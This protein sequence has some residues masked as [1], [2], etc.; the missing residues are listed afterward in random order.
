MK[1]KYLLKR[2]GA[3]ALAAMM[4][5]AS[6]PVNASE[7]STEMVTEAAT[8][9]VTEPVTVQEEAPAETEVPVE[10]EAPTEIPPETEQQTT[11]ETESTVETEP[12]GG[13]ETWEGTET[14]GETNA[15]DWFSNET[16]Q[17]TVPE[18][19]TEQ[20]IYR[21]TVKSQ[22][23]DLYFLTDLV[24]LKD[25][26]LEDPDLAKDPVPE[27]EA[28][29]SEKAAQR[30]E[31]IEAAMEILP[32]E[33]ASLLTDESYQLLMKQE[34][35]FAV[36][37]DI[38]FYAVPE[39][40]YEIDTV[41][42]ESNDLELYVTD[43]ENSAY[44]IIMPDGDMTL[45]VKVKETAE[46]PEEEPE[47][48]S[49]SEL[50][51]EP[52]SETEEESVGY[53]EAKADGM[54]MTI[55]A[56]DDSAFPKGSKLK[57]Y[58]GEGLKE[59]YTEDGEWNY[60]E[61]LSGI[62]DEWK[63]A[64]IE[65]YAELYPDQ[66]A[67]EE[68]AMKMV[69]YFYPFYFEVVEPDGTEAVL[70]DDVKVYANFYDEGAYQN[71]KQEQ[72]GYAIGY[73]AAD[74]VS[75]TQDNEV[76]VNDDKQ[77][78]AVD[79]GATENRL[80][81]FLQIHQ[82]VEKTE[83]T[84]GS[85]A[86]DPLAHEW[87]CPVFWEAFMQECTCGSN[88]QKVSD[89]DVSCSAVWMAFNAACSGCEAKD[90][91]ALHDECEVV[92]RIHKELCDCGKD[93][94]SLNEAMDSHEEDSPFIQYL[95]KLSDYVNSQIDTLAS[96][97]GGRVTTKIS[98]VSGWSNGAGHPDSDYLPLKF[99]SGK[100]TWTLLGN[101]V[102]NKWVKT[103][104]DNIQQAWQPLEASLSD[105]SS[106]GARYNNAIYD[107]KTGTWYDVA[108]VIHNY[109]RTTSGNKTIYPYIGFRHDRLLIDFYRAGDMVLRCDIYKAGTNTNAKIK[110]KVPIWDIDNCQYIGIRP[111]S[112]STMDHKYYYSG[113]D[114]YLRAGNNVSVCGTTF[115]YVEALNK[116]VDGYNAPAACAVWEMTCNRFYIAIGY[117]NNNSVS[118][119]TREENFNRMKNGGLGAGD[120][121][122]GVSIF[123]KDNVAPTLQTPVKKESADN[124][125]YS[126][127]LTLS[128]T[129]GQYY[130][131]IDYPVLDTISSHYFSSMVIQDTL[132]KGVDYVSG[133]T[134]TNLEDGKNR[135][136]W[137]TKS[138]TNDVIKFTATAD[139]LKSASFYGL[140]YRATFK[141]KMDPMEITP[142]YNT[143]GKAT[144]TVKNTASVV[145]KRGS[146]STTK[147][148]GTVTTTASLSR[149]AQPVSVKGLDGNQNLKSKKINRS[150]TITFSVFQQIKASNTAVA[151]TNIMLTDT[152]TNGLQYQ[153]FK[154]YHL[155][156][157]AWAANNN[158]NSNGTNG[159]TVKI[160]HAGGHFTA[161]DT[162]R[163]DITCKVKSNVDLSSYIQKLA[164]GYKYYVLPNTATIT[165]TY[166]DGNNV[167]SNTNQVNVYFSLGSGNLTVSKT[168]AGGTDA[169]RNSIPNTNKTFSYRL[170]G[171]STD[172]HV[173]DQTFTVTGG[174]S[175]TITG[176]PVGTFA[177]TESYTSSYWT[178]S[179]TN[180]RS[181]TVTDGG[182]ASVSFTNTALFGNL[183]VTKSI[184]GVDPSTIQD[185]DDKTFQFILSGTSAYGTS[186]NVTRSLVGSGSVSFTGIPVGN[187][188]LTERYNST[189]WKS[190]SA[191][192]TVSIAGGQTRT[193]SVTNT[194]IYNP[195]RTSQP[196]PEK[197]FDRIK[198]ISQ[199]QINK[200]SDLVTFSI[201]QQVNASEYEETAPVK[202]T[203]DDILDPAFEYQ[204]AI[205]YTSTNAGTSWIEDTSFHNSTNGNAVSVYKEQNTMSTAVWYRLDITAK[206]RADYDL[207]DY[208]QDI[209]GTAMYVIPDVASSS[210]AS[211]GDSFS[212][213]I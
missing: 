193:V 158:F 196:A 100:T 201:F 35:D 131:T 125:T 140:T 149:T 19:E 126:T 97:T 213:K 51:S 205:V 121:G 26:T 184:S 157:G 211:S 75:L 44:G 68:A 197:S 40:G 102:A 145:V 152:L 165:L 39:K 78:L 143:E 84:C 81:S 34:H 176:I 7:L 25:G 56:P 156:N 2:L 83:C 8:E 139:A 45:E 162:W 85:D 90:T 115:D 46:D 120:W 136:S 161:N 123:S 52:E 150:D 31:A 98:T 33:Y 53:L 80:Y 89:H 153:S 27:T 124:K 160:Q 108:F 187:Y 48:E 3:G 182:T 95:M 169:F 79:T 192:Q 4:T 61:F 202:L 207:D 159:Q 198:N 93:Y 69:Q 101:A 155:S 12:S 151:P 210:S 122:G 173:V 60:E 127:S 135:T 118:F 23:A 41:T 163:F 172:G 49:E 212:F 128:S 21:I 106:H 166:P 110:V 141:V 87:D 208:V 65:K 22:N 109:N 9:T 82:D 18:S 168:I 1:N 63:S 137:F 64:L 180:P 37:S 129:T 116:S 190:S 86:E 167:A 58:T 117:F 105:R 111:A 144:Y 114:S 92:S 171:T 130:Y 59:L 138:S 6:I 146:T 203:I 112:G 11:M 133:M 94:T 29:T 119:A 38:G 174:S 147:N 77:C 15:E 76:A 154:V 70:S 200:R 20:S 107:Y 99:Y 142:T 179:G 191:S 67:S 96:D 47:S 178:C 74:E 103:K 209:N 50:E 183:T 30:K 66:E 72:S 55:L 16:E 17:E 28:D 32:D 5:V 185:E 14:S 175:N 62:K 73:H 13:S 181:V 188:T 204:N 57:L 195:S 194:Y 24:K 199:E 177:V 189:M 164:D 170:S 132:P 186:V 134:V 36:A 104:I 54:D 71:A 148:T 91:Y 43:Y 88:S 206:V 10:T 42:A 113:A